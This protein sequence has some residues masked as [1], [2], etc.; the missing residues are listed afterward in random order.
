MNAKLT[1]I[2]IAVIILFIIA[3]SALF[4]VQQG[5]SALVL[6][7]GKLQV[8]SS[9]SE[10]TVYGP[11]LHVKIPFITSVRKFDMRFQTLQVASSRSY[12]SEQKA[13]FV[14]YYAKWKI[15]NL[16]LFYK[17]TGGGVSTSSDV[18][19][20]RVKN[21]LTQKINNSLKAAFGKRTIKEV[22]TDDRLSLMKILKT[23]ADESAESLGIKVADVRIQGIEL[24]PEVQDAVFNRM[25]TEREQVATKHRS[26]G[27]A[28]SES[29]KANADAHVV[30]SIAEAKSKA[31]QVRADG[32]KQAA[33]IYLT[34]YNKNASF[35]AFYQSLQAYQAVF[36]SDNSIMLLTP[37]SD[38]FKYFKSNISKSITG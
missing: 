29:I 17:R 10:A 26:Q 23:Q 24:P 18:A 35:Y 20:E 22:V 33:N 16:P 8:N 37:K 30:V 11:G 2:I 32:D 3:S 27:M 4:T 38:F 34:A 36:H 5:Q 21:L 19:T 12:T 14:D 9:T 31:Q 13:V 7:L 1:S 6:R 28:E 25:R 15:D